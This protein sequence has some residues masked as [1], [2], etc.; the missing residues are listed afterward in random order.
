MKCCEK[1]GRPMDKSDGLSITEIGIL[2]KE[3]SDTDGASRQDS[4]LAELE[5]LLER[6]QIKG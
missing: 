2:P 3:S 1:C 4:L 5:E 6:R